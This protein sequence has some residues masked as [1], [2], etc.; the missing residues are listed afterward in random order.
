MNRPPNRLVTALALLLLAAAVPAQLFH[1]EELL[2]H[3]TADGVTITLLPAQ[4]VVLSV[5]YGETEALGQRTQPRRHEAGRRATVRLEGLAPDTEYFYRVDVRG[6]LPRPVHSFRTLRNPGSTFSFAVAGDSHAWAV[7]SKG[8]CGN[9]PPNLDLLERTLF[10][11]RLDDSLDFVVLGS[12]FGMTKC[13]SCSPCSV[14]GLPVS[15]QTI[16]SALDAELRYRQVFSND[17]WG[18]VAADLPMLTVM[19]D[20]E[21]EQGWVAPTLFHWSR[22]GREKH[23]PHPGE[24]YDGGQDSH[25]YA[26]ESGDLLLVVLDIHR[27]TFE[28]PTS[29]EHYTLGPA[30]M[31]WFERTLRSSD[32]RFKVV[33]AEHLLGG[34]HQGAAETIWKGRGG[35]RATHN[36]QPNGVF[37]GE[38]AL[39]HALMK[40]HG[41]QVFLSFQ[42]HVV[43]HGEKLDADFVP[44]GVHYVIGGRSSG[45]SP[46]AANLDWYRETMD[47]DGD[48][49]PE[50]ETD[51]TG[52][53]KVGYFRI[54]VHGR[55]RLQFEY[56]ETGLGFLSNNGETLLEFD[57]R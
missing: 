40:E 13:G 8:E 11:L 45:V 41:A 33:L 16:D 55:E 5:A 24:V 50:Y 29:P 35:I 39:I 37:L 21:A 25:H 18:R 47:Y 52:T 43:A 36:G 4:P 31:A 17:L 10:N 49:V 51:V 38:Q 22:A 56:V 20:H 1:N 9:S 28:R 48:G 46:P 57:I 14:S 42:D 12:D 15:G 23:L 2:H 34:M 53:R 3:P 32:A 30:Q 54:T 26:L 7:W 44:E 6:Q 27:N 19:G